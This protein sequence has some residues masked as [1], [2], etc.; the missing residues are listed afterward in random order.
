MNSELDVFERNST[1]EV[2]KLPSNQKTIRCKWI[3]NKKISRLMDQL[4]IVRHC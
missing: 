1:W 3:F 4:K 2:I